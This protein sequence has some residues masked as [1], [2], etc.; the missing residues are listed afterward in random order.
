MAARSSQAPAGS[1][2][3]VLTI[4]R[5]FDA[6]RELVFEVFTKPE[7]LIKWWGPNGCSVVSCET[8]PEPGGRWQLMMRSPR[9]LPQ[10]ANRHPAAHEHEWIVEKQQGIYQEVVKPERL[11]FTYAFEDDAGRPLHQTVVTINFADEEGK[12][13]MILHQAVFESAS[14]RSDHVRG[15]NEALDHL[16]DYVRQTG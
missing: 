9:L 11:V 7:H 14:A 16:A 1:L 3:G 10:F 12:T 6:S 4:E 13:R 15:W 2:D 8:N 5:V